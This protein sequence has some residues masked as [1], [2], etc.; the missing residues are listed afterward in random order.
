MSGGRCQLCGRRKATRADGTI[1]AH[2]AGG[3]PC[4]GVGALPLDRDD[5][6]L[7]EI[8][9]ELELE[10]ASIVA[11]LRDLRDRRANWIDPTLPRR[12]TFLEDEAFRLRRRLKRHRDWPARYSRQMERFGYADVPPAY[13]LDRANKETHA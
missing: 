4:R 9:R 7:E 12:R 1:A 6:R 8:I 11:E 3:V 10:L 13:L 5:R 2:Y